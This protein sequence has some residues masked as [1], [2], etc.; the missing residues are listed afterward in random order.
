MAPD[1]VLDRAVPVARPWRHRSS[2]VGL[3]PGPRAGP[4]SPTPVEPSGPARGA[5]A[6]GRSR[7]CVSCPHAASR[8]HSL[9]GPG[10]VLLT[11]RDGLNPRTLTLLLLAGIAGLAYFQHYDLAI[12]VPALSVALFG[13][14]RRD[15]RPLLPLVPAGLLWLAPPLAIPFGMTHSPVINLAV[16]GVLVIGLV[17][18]WRWGRVGAP[19]LK[20]ALL[21]PR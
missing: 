21:E 17:T 5:L 9:P 15:P 7:L 13:G 6:L 14:E 18:E 4:R 11:W 1:A 3:A 16:A 8:S 12:V 20:P 10:A 19:Q 2:R